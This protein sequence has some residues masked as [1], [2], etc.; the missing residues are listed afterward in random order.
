MLLI[1]L[2]LLLRLLVLDVLYLLL[3][4][5]IG[6]SLRLG[7]GIGL[8]HFRALIGLP[9]LYTL[10]SLILFLADSLNQ[11]RLLCVELRIHISGRIRRLS[12][13]WA[14]VGRLIALRRNNVSLRRLATWIA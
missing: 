4:L 3:M 8:V 5:L 14:I 10:V 6:L 7:A 9:L 2:L 13:R 1:G 11:R 12:R